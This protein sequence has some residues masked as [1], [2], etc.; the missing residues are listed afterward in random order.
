M[1]TKILIVPSYWTG[2]ISWFTIGC[3]VMAY[4]YFRRAQKSFLQS[5]KKLQDKT[6]ELEAVMETLK[7]D[8]I[9]LNNEIM[10]VRK[11]KNLP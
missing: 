2:L 3:A 9:T 4:Y 1:V 6:L 8:A 7:K 5:A 11:L 10:E